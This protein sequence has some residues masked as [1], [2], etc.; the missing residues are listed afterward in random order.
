MQI[1]DN[2][3]VDFTQNTLD[4]S[5]TDYLKIRRDLFNI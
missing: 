4:G 5:K 1:N 3:I 2:C